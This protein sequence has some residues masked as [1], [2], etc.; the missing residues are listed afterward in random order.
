MS[1]TLSVTAIENGVVIDHIPAGQAIRI[2]SLL[3]L[4][5]HKNQV[6]IGLKFTK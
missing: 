3:G 5:A 4:A 2:I 6:T 1:K